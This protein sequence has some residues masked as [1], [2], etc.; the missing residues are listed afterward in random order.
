MSF[1]VYFWD[2]KVLPKSVVNYEFVFTYLAVG[3]VY[4][5]LEVL[6][7]NFWVNLVLLVFLFDLF[8]HFGGV[9]GA[10]S[11][12]LSRT[13]GVVLLLLVFFFFHRFYCNYSYLYNHI[14]KYINLSLDRL[15]ILSK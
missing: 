14:H 12:P 6:S 5:V 11:D 3:F 15:T 7:K 9:N 8:Y 2:G 10:T 1:H 13:V 4:Q